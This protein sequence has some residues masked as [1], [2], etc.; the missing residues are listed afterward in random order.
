[1]NKTWTRRSVQAGAIAAGF[2]IIAG[3]GAQADEA[4]S[5]HNVGALNG[6]QVLAPVQAPINLCGNAATLGGLADAHCVGGSKA[7]Y[8]GGGASLI[9]THNAG[10][11]NGNQVYAPIQAPINVC[12]NAISV[13]G[14]SSASC[15]GGTRAKHLDES[16]GHGKYHTT[17]STASTLPAHAA[18]SAL[19]QGPVG[20]DSVLGTVNSLTGVTGNIGQ[21]APVSGGVV[22]DVTDNVAN[23]LPTATEAV[24]TTEGAMTTSGSDTNLQSHHNAGLLNGN[25][26]VIPIQA[27]IDI[28]GNSISILGGSSASSEGGAKAIS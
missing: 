22:E 18:N 14:L 16:A 27:P 19:E 26:L 1:M 9:S 28:S 6:N 2:L 21:D 3:Q 7:I 15:D 4:V 17:E 13:L 10:I 8:Q 25:Q 23:V 11:G 24:P 12:G 20:V 5:S